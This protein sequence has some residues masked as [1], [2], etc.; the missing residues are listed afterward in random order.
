MASEIPTKIG[1]KSPYDVVIVSAVRT[2]LTKGRRGGFKDTRPEYLLSVVLKTVVD[3]VRLDPSMVQDIV[4]GNVL[5]PG[6]G[7]NMAHMAMLYAGFPERT[8]TMTLNRQCASGLQAVS[9][10]VS[11][12]REGLIDIGIGAGVESMTM[13]NSR[14]DYLKPHEYNQD[15]LKQQNIADCLIPMG[16][17]SENVAAD[18]N[19]TRKEQDEF[20]A[21]SHRKAIF[22]QE[23]GYFDQEI[24]PVSTFIIDKDGSKKPIIVSKDD[25]VRPG[26]TAEGLAKLKPAFNKDGSTTAG[27]ASQVSDGAAAVLLM[28]RSRAHEL[29]L[30]ILG[31]FITSATVGVPPRVMGIGPAFA[32]PAAVKKIGI[33]PQDLD[34][35]EL[36][37]AFASQAV[38]SIKH[39]GLDINKVNP[40]GGAI[41][42]GHPL[43]CTGARQVSTLLYELRRTNKKLG[44]AS[45]CM[46]SGMGMCAI[47]ESE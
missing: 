6:G 13:Y 44:A 17:T 36:N 20:A 46:G 22:A 32:I 28:K 7:A 16:I 12:I 23:N 42:F 10:V 43:G 27:N 24:V 33:S 11:A 26:T 9:Q 25:G 8:A 45:M 34:I 2:P 30:P 3:R 1:V 47:F 35:V 5:P 15:M 4:V 37:E 21:L 41:A 19:I 40:K 14:S 38:Y 31:K 18:F 29:G 39:I